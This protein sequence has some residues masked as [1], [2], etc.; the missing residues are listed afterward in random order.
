MAQAFGGKVEK[1]E[2]GWGIGL[3]THEVTARAAWMDEAERVAIPVSHQ[4]QVVVQPPS[5]R[6]LA[7]NAF[8]PFG[9]LAYA[10]QPALSMQFHPEFSRGFAKALIELRRDRLPDP[11]AALASLDGPDD[12]GRVAQWIR[13]FLA[14]GA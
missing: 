8:T 6:V 3:Q 2:K 5:S 10:D 7:A 11:D 13:N 1:S 4:D 9:M 14:E 12:R